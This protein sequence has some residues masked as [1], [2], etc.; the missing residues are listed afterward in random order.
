MWVVRAILVALVVV[1]II[2]FVVHNYDPGNEVDIDL[3][4]VTFAGVP[5]VTVVFWSFVAGV[6]VSLLLFISVYIGL[7]VQLRG[8]RRY[9]GALEEEVTVLRN[10]PIEE[11]ADLLKGVD[12]KNMAPGSSFGSGERP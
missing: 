5:V 4:Y 6:A 2:A 1:L 3:I 7:S 8:T 12:S 9:I 10:R 11:S